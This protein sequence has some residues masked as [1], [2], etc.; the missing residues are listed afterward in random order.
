[1][2][3]LRICNLRR[4][5]RGQD[6]GLQ[7]DGGQWR[8]LGDSRPAQ[9]PA[10]GRTGG[11]DADHIGPPRASGRG[12]EPRG[13]P[14]DAH[15][16]SWSVRNDAAGTDVGL[17]DARRHHPYPRLLRAGLVHGLLPGRHNTERQQ[18]RNHRSGR[19]GPGLQQP[20]RDHS[21]DRER[22]VLGAA[23]RAPSRKHSLHGHGF[24]PVPQN[25][26]HG[27]ERSAEPVI[28]RLLHRG[29]RFHAA[30]AH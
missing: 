25:S 11:R 26:R 18:S 2:A 21:S 23:Q 8:L 6:P 24:Q 7:R 16:D 4:R 10:H 17:R 28:D 15:R 20:L 13:R 29:P 14:P 12:R 22:L 19:R 5:R 30:D 27:P 3:G 1:M 9:S